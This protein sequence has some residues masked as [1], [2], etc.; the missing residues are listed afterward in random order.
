MTK[1]QVFGILVMCG[2]AAAQ[3]RGG[4]GIPNATPEQ[5]AA[6]ARMNA[7]L[8]PQLERLTAARTAAIAAAFADPRDAAAIQAKVDAV[9]A[10]EL[11]VATA[12][13]TA[14][15][16]LQASADKLTAEQVVALA[17]VAPGGRGGG[18][19]GGYRNS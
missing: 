5:T 4:R 19:R 1:R 7:D 16:K 8:A 6:V 17:Q 9:R 10:A 15:A 12:R 18:G 14:F 2:V 3:G 13:A 11:D